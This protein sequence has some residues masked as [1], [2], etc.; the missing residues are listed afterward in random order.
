VAQLF[1]RQNT[2]GANIFPKGTASDQA[3]AFLLWCPP[4][5][6]GHIGF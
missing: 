3:Q 5:F 2:S 1:D 4:V 6:S